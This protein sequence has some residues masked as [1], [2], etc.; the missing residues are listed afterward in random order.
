MTA[1]SVNVTE[2]V[3]VQLLPSVTVQV[4]VPAERTEEVE[5][6]ILT[7][8]PEADVLTQE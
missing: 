4:Y 3:V 1:G 6:P 8:V 7:T 2:A 5:A